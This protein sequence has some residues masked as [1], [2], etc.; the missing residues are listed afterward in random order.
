MTPDASDAALVD[1]FGRQISYLRLSVTDRCD[2]RCGYCLPRG[3]KGG[4]APGDWL[5]FAEIVRVVGAFTALGVRHVRLTGGEPLMRRGLPDLAASL[6]ALPGLDD[7]S[8][9]SNCTRMAAFAEPLRRAGVRRLNVS[10]DSL[11]PEVFRAITGGRL[12]QVLVGIEAAREAG[13]APIRVNTVVMRGVNDDEIEDILAYCIARGFTLR[14]IETMPMGAG[15][16]ATPAH[17]LALEEVRR[18]LARRFDLSP[19]LIQGGGPARYDRVADSETRI[20]FI[21]PISRHFCATCNRV[22]LAVDGTL[23]LCLGQE[24]AYP[25][26]ALLRAGLD[27][28]ELATHLRRAIALKPKRHLLRERLGQVGRSLSAIGG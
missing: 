6:A 12:A 26:R 1:G 20:G 17:Y 28:T 25:L 19:D 11:R 27:E 15:R 10:L 5:S 4:E 24:G 16:L 7:L 22:R 13:L 14:L 8:I 3:F 21:T 9:S 18:R 23:H 2:L